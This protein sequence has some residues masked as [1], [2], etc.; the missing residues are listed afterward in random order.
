MRQVPLMWDGGDRQSPR[1][2]AVAPVVEFVEKTRQTS[3]ES[4]LTRL[5]V[6]DKII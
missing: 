6:S 2:R 1:G 4:A 3:Y 5:V